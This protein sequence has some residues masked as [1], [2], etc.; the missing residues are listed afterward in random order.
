MKRLFLSLALGS[1]PLIAAAQPATQPP[2]EAASFETVSVTGTGHV[3]LTPDRFTFNVGVQTQAPTVEDTVNQNNSRV[4]AVNAALKKAGATD[5]E[6]RTTGFSIYPQQDFSQQGQMPR[7]L[8]YQ[9]TN[10]VTVSRK[11]IDDAGRLLQ[12]AIAAGVNQAS[13]IQ[14]EVSNPA[15]GRDE[16]L[17]A[18]FDDAR[19]KAQVLATAAGRTLGRALSITEGGGAEPPRP[20]PMVRA[21]A[22]QAKVSEV[23]VESGSQELSF[24]VSVLFEL[25]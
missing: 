22:M 6:I 20:M 12:A 15:R 5:A 8:G 16:G 25:K 13:G 11:Q 18:A 24:T 14:F 9:V 2:R 1:I 21:M 23:P 4:A 10:S 19:R 7:L 3:T 17:K